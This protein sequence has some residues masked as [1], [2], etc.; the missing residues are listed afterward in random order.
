MLDLADVS[1]APVKGLGDLG[2]GAPLDHSQ[3]E[4]LLPERGQAPERL[5]DEVTFDTNDEL[6]LCARR[7]GGSMEGDL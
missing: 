2:G 1:S 5:A 4:H 6:L 7:V 3:D